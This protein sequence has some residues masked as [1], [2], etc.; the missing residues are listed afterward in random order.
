MYFKCGAVELEGLTLTS[1]LFFL[2]SNEKY[3]YSLMGSGL[4]VLY[5]FSLGDHRESCFLFFL[6]FPWGPS[7]TQRQFYITVLT[8]ECESF[9]QKTLLREHKTGSN[10]QIC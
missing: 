1:S 3:K 5:Q 10:T 2:F 9:L 6:D 7:R 8:T 4:T